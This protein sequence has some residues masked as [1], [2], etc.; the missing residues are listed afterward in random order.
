MKYTSPLL[1]G[2]HY[3]IHNHAIGSENLFRCKENY[4]YFLEKYSQYIYP[5]CETYAYSLMPNHFHFSIKVRSSTELKQHLEYL[6]KNN[7]V[8]S[9]N[10][11]LPLFIMQQ[12]S[13]LFNGYTKAYNKMF[14][15]KGALFDDYMKRKQVTSK[16]YFKQLVQYIHQNPV[17]HK[18]C[19]N[20]YDWEF[21]S[22]HS[23]LSNGK[24]QL[25]REPI[26]E[27]FGGKEEFIDSH[28]I[29]LVNISEL[30]F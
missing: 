21:S 3:H 5:I 25:K 10:E 2:N 29:L 12:F 20:A 11:N 1:S 6:K 13:N 26:L 27:L 24:T 17:H 30:E 16:S 22:Y 15:R 28:K 23:F 8:L 18:F 14:D 7:K 4:Y 9:K 19:K